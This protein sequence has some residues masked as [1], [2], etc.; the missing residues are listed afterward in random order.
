MNALKSPMR[1]RRVSTSKFEVVYDD[2]LEQLE[3]PETGKSIML[4]ASEVQHENNIIEEEE[5]RPCCVCLTVEQPNAILLDCTHSYLCYE[6][7][8]VSKQHSKECMPIIYKLS[9]DSYVYNRL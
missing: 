2:P 6:C 3:D 9:D 4:H 7:A 8:K 1:V 5:C